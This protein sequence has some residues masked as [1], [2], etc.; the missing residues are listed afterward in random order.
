MGNHNP[1]S[2]Y[3]CCNLKPNERFNCISDLF[4]FKN[5]LLVKYIGGI[6]EL[7][8]HTFFEYL[9]ILIEKKTRYNLPEIYPGP[10]PLDRES[11]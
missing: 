3:K 11:A 10:E 1:Q 8:S 4:R 6:L 7:W 5:I 2:I 9:C